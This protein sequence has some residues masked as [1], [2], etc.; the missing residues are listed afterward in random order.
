MSSSRKKK[1]SHSNSGPANELA[2]QSQATSQEL[3]FPTK[4]QSQSQ[5][6]QQTQQS[7]PPWS[8]HTPPSGRWPSPFP[9][10]FHAL[11]T[12][13]TAAGEL[14]LFGGKIH[15][16]IHNDLYVISTRDFSTTLLQTSGNVPN[17]RYGHCAVLTST[18]LLIWGGFTNFSDQVMQNQAH[19]DSLYLLN[20]VSREWTRLV[21]DGPG[22]GGRYYHTMTLVG[23]KLFV[24]GGRTAKRRFN[25]IWA[26]DLN[27]LNSNPF[28]ESYEP[29]IGNEKPLPRAA[30]VSVTTGD[31]IIIFGGRGGAHD[32]NDTW[33]FNISTRKWT[34]L[35]C[36]GSIPSP[37]ANHAAVLIDDVMYVY[38]GRSVGRTNLGDLTALNLST[39]RWIAFQDI[40]SSPSGRSRHAMACD[41]TRVFVLGGELSPGAQADDTKLIHVLDTKHL[42]YPDPDSDA[43]NSNEKTTQ[44]VRK[45]SASPPTRGQPHQPS[46]FRRMPMQHMVLLLS[47]KLPPENWTAPPLCRLL[48]IE[49]LV[50]MT[51]HRY[52]RV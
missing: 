37:R 17:P 6:P 11:S 19:D 43:V 51:S 25:D 22:P 47:K 26:L 34:E 40:G 1:H 20:L 35:Q 8:A 29:A 50:R 2:S 36:T 28:W 31:R 23:S 52:S 16:G 5:S 21:I 18:I 10:R 32:F 48:A 7:Q 12:I 44:L 27:S 33:S 3:Q 30:H 4:S 49:P 38:G 42:D 13:A 39:H 9:R 15:D 41:G 24:F 46:S 45:S 14:F